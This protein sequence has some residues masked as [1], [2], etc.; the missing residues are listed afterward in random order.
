M[1][2]VRSWTGGQVKMRGIKT[3]PSHAR[4]KQ[5]ER[6][7]HDVWIDRQNRV[8][9][10]MIT[11]FIHKDS[12]NEDIH[13]RN[14]APRHDDSHQAESHAITMTWWMMRD[15]EETRMRNQMERRGGAGQGITTTAVH[16]TSYLPGPPSST[17]TKWRG[18]SGEPTIAGSS[19]GFVGLISGI[20][21]VVIVSLFAGIYFWNRYRRRIGPK[22]ANST[23]SHN[24]LPSLSFSRP[25]TDPYAGSG[26]EDRTP[27]AS[28]FGFTRP[29]YA[30]QRSSEWDMPMYG[31]GDS[32]PTQIEDRVG[33]SWVE[34]DKPDTHG[35][36]SIP[37]R[38]SRAISPALS[39]IPATPTKAQSKGKGKE[40]LLSRH[41]S[42]SSI[43]KN[44]F[45]NP[46]DES[47]LSPVAYRTHS[48]QSS[49]DSVRGRENGGEEQEYLRVR[50]GQ[51]DDGA[52]SGGQSDTSSSIRVSRIREG[53][54]FVERFESKESLA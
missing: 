41:D 22:S 50:E 54:R 18:I 9:Y 20:A 11:A 29:V 24:P 43:T 15:Y 31:D 52:S 40:R 26:A 45:D 12:H 42:N 3:V 13:Q 25:S 1:L 39:S 23:R 36:A 19:G 21:V 2:L 47:H 6:K 8:G 14:S 32:P 53:S 44:P 34:V 37:L 51:E 35:E 5:H 38:T 7:A 10:E 30:R 48:S 17:I 49:V 16:L 28:N 27:K 4:R 46:Y 33:G